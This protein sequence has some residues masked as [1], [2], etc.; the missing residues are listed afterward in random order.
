MYF[1][2]D[3]TCDC[4][5]WGWDIH[6][7]SS[8]V[9]TRSGGLRGP[10]PGVVKHNT[11]VKYSVNFLSPV[12]YPTCM[13]SWKFGLTVTMAMSSSWTGSQANSWGETRKLLINI[14]NLKLKL[15]IKS[16]NLQYLHSQIK[17]R[18][19]LQTTS[20]VQPACMSHH[21]LS[22]WQKWRQKSITFCF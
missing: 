21:T 3:Y 20:T 17:R 11:E 4:K 16:F 12:I 1:D 2:K 13:L 8:C 14:D 6:S 9:R 22:N 15:H 10:S 18:P 5:H 19:S 7:L